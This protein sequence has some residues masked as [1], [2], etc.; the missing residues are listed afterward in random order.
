MQ[1][2]LNRKIDVIKNDANGVVLECAIVQEQ[3][4]RVLV[5]REYGAK[6]TFHK[7]V[8]KKKIEEK[9]NKLV[10]NQ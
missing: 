9:K 1:D 7:W 2:L 4:T 3:K 6:H 5:F 10:F 8:D